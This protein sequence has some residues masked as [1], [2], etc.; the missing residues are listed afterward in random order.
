MA[1]A[2]T[3]PAPSAA[4]KAARG[5]RAAASRLPR[6]AATI[7]QMAP[8]ELADPV[9]QARLARMG[10]LTNPA[11]GVSG[12][13]NGGPLASQFAA[14]GAGFQQTAIPAVTGGP[15]AG[16]LTPVTNVAQ[17]ATG[18]A[19]SAAARAATQ[20]GAI[21]LAPYTLDP[22]TMKNAAQAPKYGRIGGM[23]AWNPTAAR[24][25]AAANPALTS[26][27]A[28]AAG[29]TGGMLAPG[30]LGRAG[31]YGLGGFVAANLLHGVVGERDGTWDDAGEGALKGAG[32]GAGIGSMIFPGPGTAI[33]GALGGIGGAI[34]GGLTGNDTEQKQISD[35]LGN[36]FNTNDSNYGSN[37]LPSILTSYGISPDTTHEIITQIQALGPTL[38]SKAEAEALVQGVIGQLPQL[39]AQDEARKVETSRAAAM[40]AYLLPMMREQQ[41]QSSQFMSQQSALLNDTAGRISN[42]EVAAVYR[43]HAMS[44]AA[45]NSRA[46]QAYMTQILTAP[47]LYAQQQQYGTY[48]P[49]DPNGQSTA[50]YAGTGTATGYAP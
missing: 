3:T 21:D 17:S 36:Q 38:K 45:S 41:Q 7:A 39:K 5:V 46:N 28:A 15:Y 32:I 22:A 29:R 19:E 18:A 33:G 50:A 23:L 43:Q 6:G 2:S 48:N 24:A 35:Y 16:P 31:A 27:E 30:S 10:L 26:A 25:A 11:Q 49:F 40:Q 20:A 1:L 4:R 42:P 12:F 13:A 34:W 8:A 47:A 9:V 37:S 14:P 44:M